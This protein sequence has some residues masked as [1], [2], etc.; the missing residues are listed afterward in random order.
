M[1][2]LP[3][4]TR[5]VCPSRLGWSCTGTTFISTPFPLAAGWRRSVR[6]VT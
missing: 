1:P 5:R 2:A 3:P 6:A 4:I